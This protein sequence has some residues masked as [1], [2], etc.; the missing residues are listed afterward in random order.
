MF[1]LKDFTAVISNFKPRSHVMIVDHQ[2]GNIDYNNISRYIDYYVD[3]VEFVSMGDMEYCCCTRLSAKK[4]GRDL[5]RNPIQF[6]DFIQCL[7]G[8]DQVIIPF[9]AITKDIY[10]DWINN[11]TIMRKSVYNVIPVF[12]DRQVLLQ[13]YLN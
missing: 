11:D 10:W 5:K 3:K 4:G 6:D 13:V 2:C 9:N 8:M 12:T 1:R 7:F